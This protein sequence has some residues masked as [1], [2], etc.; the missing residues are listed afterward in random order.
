MRSSHADR[1]TD[2]VRQSVR[3]PMYYLTPPKLAVVVDD[4]LEPMV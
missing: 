1:F 4:M 2:A 3:H